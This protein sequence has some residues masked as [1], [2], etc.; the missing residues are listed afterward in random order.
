[1]IVRSRFRVRNSDLVT[2]AKCHKNLML[3][4]RKRMRD[5]W[6]LTPLPRVTRP[7]CQVTFAVPLGFRVIGPE[8]PTPGEHRFRIPIGRLFGSGYMSGLRLRVLVTPSVR[9]SHPQLVTHFSGR[10]RAVAVGPPGCRIR[11][12]VAAPRSQKRP[13]APANASPRTLYRSVISTID[14]KA[15]VRSVFC[16]GS[17]TPYSSHLLPN[18]GW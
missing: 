12:Q 2:G 1:M 8:Y 11:S 7:V 15:C 10:V 3:I 16:R 14:G 9:G 6:T 17:L 5:R 18:H 4:R 13:F